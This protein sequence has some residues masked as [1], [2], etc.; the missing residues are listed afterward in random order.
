MTLLTPVE[1]PGCTFVYFIETEEW[2]PPLQALW[3]SLHRP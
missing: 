1:C 2:T 3:T